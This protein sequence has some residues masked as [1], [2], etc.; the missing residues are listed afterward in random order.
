MALRNPFRRRYRIVTINRQ[1]GR[2]IPPEPPQGEW[3]Y[4]TARRANRQ[5]EEF[6]RT[7]KFIGNRHFYEVRYND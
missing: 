2:E 5:M 7:A 3:R 4:W 6:N 1:T